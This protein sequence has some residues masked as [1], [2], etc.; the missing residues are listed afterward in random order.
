MSSRRINNKG[1]HREDAEKYTTANVAD[2]LLQ[3]SDPADE[4]LSS[5]ASLN[6]I[7][8]KAI[9]EQLHKKEGDIDWDAIQV[10]STDKHQKILDCKVEVINEGDLD[11][12][13]KNVSS[14]NILDH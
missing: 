1:S 12:D 8:K 2:V 3:N 13:Q 11:E 9:L 14:K 5:A 6:E 10:I 7:Q 4:A